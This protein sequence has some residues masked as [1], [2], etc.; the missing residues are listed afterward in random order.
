MT[1]VEIKLNFLAPA[2]TG[3][4][5]AKGRSIKVGETLCLGEALIEDERGTLLAHGTSTMMALR[6]LTIKEGSAF[7]P[8]F[9]E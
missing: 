3:R 4:L 1:T 6:E 7:P 9:L 2:S 8:K 5:I